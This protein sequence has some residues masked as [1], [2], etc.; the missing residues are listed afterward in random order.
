METLR[1]DWSPLLLYTE[2]NVNVHVPR[3][4]GVYRLSYQ[5]DDNRRVFYVGQDDNLYE[6][7]RDHSSD[8][9]TNAC[10]RRNL[11]SY[12]CFVQ[13]SPVRNIKDRDGAERALYDH[14]NPECNE[15]APP[16]EPSNVNFE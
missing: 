13:F 9:E 11:Q 2:F 5:S 14:H 4:A 16:G 12:T 8:G 7:L 15:V 3:S 1:L 6:R 10:I